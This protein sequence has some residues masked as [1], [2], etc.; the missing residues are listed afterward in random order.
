MPMV[1]DGRVECVDDHRGRA[2]S[3]S[4]STIRL[5][6]R[7]AMLHAAAIHGQAGEKFHIRHHFAYASSPTR[8]STRRRLHNQAG[9]GVWANT[10]TSR[11]R[12]EVTNQPDELAL[13][14][15]R[16][17]DLLPERHVPSGDSQRMAVPTV[18][19]IFHLLPREDSCQALRRRHICPTLLELGQPI[20]SS[21]LRQHLPPHLRKKKFLPLELVSQQVLR[22]FQHHRPQHLW[23]LHQQVG[24][25]IAN[26]Q[27]ASHVHSACGW[28]AVT[29]FVLWDAL[30]FGWFGW[31][32]TWYLW[33]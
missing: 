1:S 8:A 12:P 19:P 15:L 21:T 25:W 17:R 7:G 11:H 31:S 16:Q 4:E 28:S 10:C 30:P 5:Q 3:S 27:S 2:S 20:P 9:K 13:S 26:W 29:E 24:F 14:V 6:Q 22:A 33:G 18:A 32:W 23:R